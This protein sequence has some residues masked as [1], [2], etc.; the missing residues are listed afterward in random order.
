MFRYFRVLRYFRVFRVFHDF[1]LSHLN[2]QYE[3]Q[4]NFYGNQPLDS[5]GFHY[6]LCFQFYSK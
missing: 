3:T 5:P 2:C 4:Q 6:G 1:L